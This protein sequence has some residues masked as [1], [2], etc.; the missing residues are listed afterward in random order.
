M[1]KAAPKESLAMPELSLY[2]FCMQI[3]LVMTVVGQDRPGLIEAVARIVGDHGGNWLESRMCRLGGEFAGILRVNVP[4]ENKDKF[5]QSLGELK[6]EGLTVV[7]QPD[8]AMPQKAGSA[9]SLTLV[10]Q[11]RPGIV[12]EISHVIARHGVNIEEL[13]TECSSAPMSGEMLFSAG[14]RLFIPQNCDVANLRADLELIAADLQV[15]IRFEKASEI[16]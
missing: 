9:A 15:E 6:S 4:A 1:Q 14:A 3:P 11:D 7:V 10:G 13:E 2:Q 5:V 8:V 12:R 16:K